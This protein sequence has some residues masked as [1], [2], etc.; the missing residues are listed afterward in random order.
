MQGAGA[1]R[2]GAIKLNIGLRGVHAEII[3][4][5]PNL[6]KHMRMLTVEPDH[7]ENREVI[8]GVLQSFLA[9]GFSGIAVSLPSGQEVTRAGDFIAWPG[10]EVRLA[11]ATASALIWK[12][13]VYLLRRLSLRDDKGP[14]GSMTS[15]QAQTVRVTLRRDGQDAILAVSD[16]GIGMASDYDWERGPSLG[17]KLATNL[18]RQLGGR[19]VMEVRDG[20]HFQVEIKHL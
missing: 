1:R 20:T 7:P 4:S 16:D 12:E 13:G 19:L 17:L 3:T 6:L 2:A 8:R 10:M 14:L 5:R 11:G 18:A 9:H 15:L